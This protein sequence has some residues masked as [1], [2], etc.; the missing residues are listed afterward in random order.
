MSLLPEWA[1]QDAIQLS[2]PHPNSAWKPWLKTAW[3]LYATLCQHIS[4][5]QKVLISCDPSL[6]IEE[7]T[8]LLQ[9]HNTKLENILL[10]SVPT[11][12]VWARDHG[13][14]T[15]RKN[16]QLRILDFSFNAWGGKYAY[17]KDNLINRNLN[18]QGAYA[19]AL[20]QVALVLEGGSIEYDGHGTLM[21]TSNC[22]L[23][24]N[25]NP[26]LSKQQ[27]AHQLTDHFDLKQIIWLE[28]GHLEGDDTDA[29]IDTL[30]RFGPDN[31]LIYVQCLDHADVHFEPLRRMEDELKQLKDADNQPYRLFPLPMASAIH[32]ENGQRLPA[33]YANFLITNHQV[34]VPIYG[35]PEDQQALDVMRQ[36]FP[37]YE[38]VGV[39][40]QVLIEQYGSLHC[41]TMQLP[42][43]TLRS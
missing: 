10:K 32:A 18:E 21:T 1:P 24:P 39:N 28:N 9:E 30:A 43:G 19:A 12:D 41:I 16:D 40:C 2:W 7:I 31:S 22:L 34:L 35:Q 11:N 3:K 13:P 23:N 38:I 15:V 36:A 20:E 42:K 17:D 6:D 5:Y 26:T 25:R 33:T 37:G 14:I 29:H 8:D 4:Q 27:I